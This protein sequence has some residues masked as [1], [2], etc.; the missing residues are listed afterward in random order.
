MIFRLALKLLW[1]DWRAGEL[2]LLLVSLVI[3]VG[4]VTTMTLFVDRLQ[5]ALLLESASFLAA[6]RVISASTPIEPAIIQQAEASGLT[7]SQTL[8]FL[9]MV[10]S[11]DRAQFTSVKAVNEPY[12]LRG[13]LIAGNEPFMRGAPVPSGPPPGELW[14]ESR[15]FPMLNVAPG[16]LVDLGIAS[17]PVTRVLIKEPDRVGG[18][19]SAGPRLLMN[20]ADVA[21]TG[22][23]QPGSR[24]RY[25]YQFAG[26]PEQIESFEAWAQPKLAPG[27]RIF[28]VKEGA[29]S[30]GRTLERGERFLLLGSLLG[31]LLAGVAIALA[32]RRYSLRHYGHVMILKTLGAK[33]LQI[34]GI[35]LIIF[36]VLGALATLLGA[37]TGYLMQLGVAE[38]L[39]PLIPVA[40]PAPTWRPLL[41]GL[42][43]GFVCLLSFALPPLLKLRQTPPLRLIRQDL[44]DGNPGS[45]TLTSLVSPDKLTSLF[46]L[47]GILGM[48]WWYSQDLALTLMI[49][50]GAAAALVVLFGVALLLLGGGRALGMRA[51]S[52][53]R[54]ALAGMQRRKQENTIQILVFGIAIMLLLVLYLVRTALIAEWQAQIPEDAPNHF[55]INIAPEEVAP[56]QSLFAA[57]DVASQPLYPMIRGRVLSI[58]GAPTE[59]R[60]PDQDEQNVPASSAGRNLTWAS[61]LPDDNQLVAGTWWD[62]YDAAIPL[63]SIEADLAQRNG[64]RL[65][66]SLTFG[67]Q[68]RELVA[69]VASIRTVFWDNMQPNFYIIFSPGALDDFPAMFMTSFFLD[70]HQKLFLN[71]LLSQHPT[72]TVIEVDALLEQMQR[73]LSQVTLA[74]ELVLVLTIASGILVLLT[75][76]QASMDKRLRQH[77]LLRA[78][79]ASRRLVLGS[80]LVEFGTLGLFAGILAALGAEITLYL[81]ETEAFDLSY[82]VNPLFWVLGPLS[83]IVLIG[84]I[85]ILATRRLVT[86]PPAMILNDEVC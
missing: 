50:S 52:V 82:Q 54:L 45:T 78:L 31:V 8:N 34:D 68:G 38:I 28:G 77:A 2:T 7:H 26:T 20:L 66:D 9:S 62:E 24:L 42:G 39:S 22:V 47:L 59:T 12:P 81:L 46:A 79:G 71:Q 17:M 33:P 73:V 56:V 19:D 5:N 51:G 72:M 44:D 64:I 65:G 40:L 48:L 75:S 41:P 58:N 16:D 6:D 74:I 85:G 10:F 27:A 25:R 29:A 76:I 35:F 36:G 11:A 4:T 30:I 57:N 3:A 37:G 14:M 55:A 32:A 60:D 15:L 69:Q 83:G 61:R 21:R 86:T 43:T 63:V 80:L 1:R 18:F 53:W 13:L 49:L 70:K 67:I 23:V 84:V